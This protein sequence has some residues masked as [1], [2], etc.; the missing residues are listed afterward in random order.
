MAPLVWLITGTTSGIGEAL[1]KEVARR[2]DKVIATGRN[3]EE[4]LQSL[5]SDNIALLDLDVASSREVINAQINTAVSIFGRI[6]VLI[7]NAGMSASSSI[8]EA[9]DAFMQRLF[10]V[11]L[12]GTIRVTQA[13]LPYMRKQRFGRIGCIGAGLAWAPF[14]FLGFYSMTKAAVG[15]FVEAL[16]KETS[17]FGIRATCFEPGGFSTR[18]GQ[19][20]GTGYGVGAMPAVEDYQPGFTCFVKGLVED[21]GAS[22]PGDTNKLPPAV[23][24]VIKG[25]GMAAERKWPMRV[26]LG[27]DTVTLIRQK[28]NEQLQ[29]T[30]EWEDVSNSVNAD[31]WSGKVSQYMMDTCSILR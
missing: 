28:C 2:G 13:V 3:A 26:V 11:N 9:S 29:L 16:D 19:A 17:A 8:E 20:R 12:F 15:Q 25:E 7:N 1:V 31:D 22:I 5:K 27:Q 18:L 23:I 14:P 4:R 10:D 6:D 30:A 21:C 24:D